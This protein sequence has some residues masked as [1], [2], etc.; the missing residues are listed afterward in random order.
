MLNIEK[1]PI[2]KDDIKD[3]MFQLITACYPIC[4]S[5]TG[6]GVRETIEIIRK[7]IPLDKHEVPSGTKV[8]DWEIPKEWNIKQA[9][10]KDP[11]GNVIV[12]YKRHNL[13][14]LNYSIP[15]RKRVGLDELKKHLYT[16]PEQ[17]D[18]IPYRNSYY[19]ENWGFCLSHNQMI[20]LKEGTY[21]VVIDTSLEDGHL[22]YGEYF[23][24]GNSSE[25][26][27]ISTHICH[28]SLCNDNLS[29]I[30]VSTYLAKYLGEQTTRY[31]YRFLFIP[32]TIGSI[33][34]LSLNEQNLK[35]KHG[36]V[37]ALLG[38]LSDFTYKR[39]RKGNSEIDSV[40]E[41]CLQHSN[42]TYTI[43]DF[44][45]YGYD[46]RQYCSPGINL[47]VGCFTRAPYG[48]FP[49]YH[50]S[51]DNLEFVKPDALAESLA[52]LYEALFVLENNLK[53][54]S[55]YPK[56][57]PQLGKRGLYQQIG[58]T[59]EGKV[60]QLAALWVLNMS[61]GNYSLLD[62]AKKSGI[63]FT[64]IKNAA[65]ALINCDLIEKYAKE[66]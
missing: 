38:D 10:I 64:V 46:E 12:D 16:I 30:A 56:C 65:D 2:Q 59:N 66:L 4:R 60:T 3:R 11:N 40:I 54:V 21:E 35:I 18:L 9:Y 52:T 27:L 28:P 22:T 51:A 50:T 5:I 44:I 13:H 61:D 7:I 49:E 43:K 34:W 62:I 33:A 14:V 45:P 32:V 20:R 1:Y 39:T 15:I 48:E 24:Q 53:Y 55:K 8:Y 63:Q 36:L 25:E 26:I 19:R 57:E 37:L 17:P 47:S 31:S 42:K 6:D 41:H 29:G 23:I 58:G